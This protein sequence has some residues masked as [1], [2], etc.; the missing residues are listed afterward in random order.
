MIM[1]VMGKF[2]GLRRGMMRI[3]E[4]GFLPFVLEEEGGRILLGITR[5]DEKLMCGVG[6]Q[7]GVCV[8]WGVVALY[9]GT[10]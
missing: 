10:L 4:F 5:M 8:V 7:K 2:I 9:G 6:G 1:F 3:C